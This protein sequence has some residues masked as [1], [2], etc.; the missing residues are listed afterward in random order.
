MRMSDPF[1]EGMTPIPV[2]LE[3]QR[4]PTLEEYAQGDQMFASWLG[5]VDSYCD[6]FLNVPFMAIEEQ[7]DAAG[8]YE[9]GE[10]PASF[11][12]HC[13]LVYMMDEHGHDM[14]EELIGEN[15]MW[16]EARAE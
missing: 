10:S 16:G 12:R 6:R 7:L 9:H 14:I 11:F 1:M 15:A 4:F 13:V 8:S 5:T 3:E 2:D